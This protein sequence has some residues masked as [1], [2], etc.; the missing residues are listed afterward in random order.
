MRTIFFLK[1]QLFI[2]LTASFDKLFFSLKY[3][4]NLINSLFVLYKFFSVIK[5]L[6]PC[7]RLS[8]IGEK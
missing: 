5:S 2:S 6:S 7:K 4:Q 3:L 1:A 8:T